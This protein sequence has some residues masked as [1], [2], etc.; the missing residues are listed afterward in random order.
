MKY[1]HS[2]AMTNV[3]ISVNERQITSDIYYVDVDMTFDEPTHPSGVTIQWHVPIV[4]CYSVLGPEDYYRR[5]LQPSWNRRVNTSCFCYG[6]TYQQTISADGQN[7]MTIAVSDAAIPTQ[8][9]SGVHEASVFFRCSVSF[10]TEP[11]E[12]ITE[13]HILAVTQI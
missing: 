5:N 13:Y 6:G 4:D 9:T 8:I 7:R 3:Q 12:K 10:F 11:T 1:T 2:T